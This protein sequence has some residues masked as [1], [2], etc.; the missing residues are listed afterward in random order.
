MKDF[1]EMNVQGQRTTSLE[2]MFV[3]DS[4]KRWTAEEIIDI[5]TDEEKFLKLQITLRSITASGQRL[6]EFW[7]AEFSLLTISLDGIMDDH[8]KKALLGALAAVGHV[9]DDNIQRGMGN[10]IVTVISILVKDKRD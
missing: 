5:L 2:K 1:I 10:H 3:L 8:E 4:V 9:V 6:L 7:N